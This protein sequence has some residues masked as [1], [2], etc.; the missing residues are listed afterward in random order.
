MIQYQDILGALTKVIKEYFKAIPIYGDEVREGYKKPS[1]FIGILPV[2]SINHTKSIREEQLL[3][4]VSYFSNT[5]QSLK[6]YKVLQE[7]KMLLGQVLSV[8]DRKLTISEMTT[9]QVGEEGDIYQISFSLHYYELANAEDDS[10]VATE[11]IF[12][13][14]GDN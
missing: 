2:N 10:P 9:H 6:N 3:V 13:Q 7:L 14:K 8:G 11:F 1:F 12:K 4:T 5:S